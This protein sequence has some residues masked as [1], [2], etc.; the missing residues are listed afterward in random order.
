MPPLISEQNGIKPGLLIW[1]AASLTAQH[2]LQLCETGVSC[3]FSFIELTLD[4]VNLNDFN[5]SS[6]CAVVEIESGVQ[7][8]VHLVGRQ[9]VGTDHGNLRIV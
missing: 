2:P 6:S 3:K 8:E 1:H 4:S 5:V 9:L 7:T